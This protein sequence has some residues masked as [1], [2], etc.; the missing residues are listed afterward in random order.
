M[1]ILYL[2]GRRVYSQGS[3]LQSVTIVNLLAG[4]LLEVDAEH[5][6]GLVGL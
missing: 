3:D 1:W 2:N 5:V 4:L 6:G